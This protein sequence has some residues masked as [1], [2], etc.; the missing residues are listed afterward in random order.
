MRRTLAICLLLFLYI[1][2]AVFLIS[3]AQIFQNC[4]DIFSCKTSTGTNSNGDTMCTIN[5]DINS[6][7][8]PKQGG[9]EAC[10]NTGCVQQCNCTCQGSAQNWTG[11][12][13]SWIDCNNVV[14]SNTRQCSGCPC[15][16]ENQDCD[17]N[18]PCCEGQGLTCSLLGR[19]EPSPSPTPTPEHGGPYGCTDSWECHALGCWECVCYEGLCSYATPILIDV[20]GNGFALTSASAGVNFDLNN[21]GVAR[22]LAWTAAASDDA[23]LALDRNGNALVDNGAELFGDVTPQPLPPSGV[24][25]NGFLALAQ[26]DKPANA[27]NGDGVID[28]RDT[29]FSS[30]RLWQDTNHNGTSE[31]SELHRLSDLGLESISLDYK[32]S[33]K[34]DEHGNQFRYRAKVDDAKHLKVGRWAWDVFLVSAP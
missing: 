33:K 4:R 18:N 31:A 7:S 11:T 5:V 14:Q 24:Q 21:D 20:S 8:G 23:W 13:T 10:V 27:G 28:S 9:I 1:T 34:T 29:V 30:L 6:C 15:K 2:S 3:K 32:L 16:T 22:R 12:A 19:C 17:A 26:Y 25:R